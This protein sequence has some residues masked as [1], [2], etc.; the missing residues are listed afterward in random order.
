[1]I[2]QIDARVEQS[3]GDGDFGVICRYQ[4]DENLYMF[5]ITQD[6]YY[7]I[8]KLVNAEWYPLIDYTYSDM[9]VNLKE[10]R[11]NAACIGDTLSFAV[12]GKLMGEV[13][14]QSIRE[15]DYGFFAGTFDSGGNMVSFDN[16]IISRP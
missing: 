15:G 2:I 12:N 3:S 11:F 7:A 8:Y 16:V 4:D 5:E 10:A 6:A 14:D 13:S 9:L 1:V